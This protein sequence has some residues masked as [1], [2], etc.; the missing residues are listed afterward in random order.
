MSATLD[1]IIEEVRT[2]SPD[3]QR[4]LRELLERETRP[5]LARSIR[6]KYAHLTTSSE[7]FIAQKHEETEREDSKFRDRQ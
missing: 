2:L 4:Q 5:A 7:A 1:K 6:G 3:E